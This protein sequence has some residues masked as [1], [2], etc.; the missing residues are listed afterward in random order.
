MLE[1][2][3]DE[4]KRSAEEQSQS[5]HAVEPAPRLPYGRE[6]PGA[7]RRMVDTAQFYPDA[8]PAPSL[9]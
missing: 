9:R 5:V 2:R 8:K 7:T 6:Q 1:R 4:R 3:G